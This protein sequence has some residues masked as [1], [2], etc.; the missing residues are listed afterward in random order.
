LRGPIGAPHFVQ[1][2]VARRRSL[3]RRTDALV[4]AR[5]QSWQ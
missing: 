4:R 1:V 2:R 3:W 5:W